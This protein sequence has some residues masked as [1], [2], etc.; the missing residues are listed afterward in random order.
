MSTSR[1]RDVRVNIVSTDDSRGFK[2]A[3]A[4]AKV[5]ERELNKLE[6]QQRRHVQMH[7]Q[8]SREMAAAEAQKA[9]A[10]VEANRRQ[11]DAMQTSGRVLLGVTAAIAVGMGIAAKAAWDWESSWAGVTKTVDGSPE[12]MAALERELRALA[13]TLPATH[14]EIAGVAE[15]AGQLGVRRQDIAG[16]TRT[17]IDLG[18]TTNLSADEAST[19]LAQ[20][21]NIMGLTAAKSSQLGSALVAL[22]NDGASTERDIMG[23]GLRI[24]GAGRTVGLTAPQVLA[25][26]SALSSLGIEAEAGGTAISRVMLQ[27]DSDIA[28]G[29][30]TVREYA[31]V[32]GMSADDFARKWRT[33]PA[34]ALDAFIKGLGRMQSAGQNTTKTLADLGL[35]EVRVSDTLRRA[36]L[37]GDLLTESLRTGSE[38]FDENL[39]LVEE[40][41]KR[42]ATTESRLQMARNSMNDAAIDIGG[43]LLPALAG[44]ADGAAS[45]AAGFG[46]LSPEVQGAVTGL[47]LAVAGVTGLVGTA[48]VAIPKLAEL[49]DLVTDLRGGSS[50][51]GR[52]L[53]GAASVLT[54]PWGLAIAGATV[55]VG[56]WLKLQGDARRA[57]DTL[58]ASL[59]Q[60]TGAMTTNTRATVFKQLQDEGRDFIEMAR[61]LKVDM[62]DLVDAALDPTS[63]A[64]SRLQGEADKVT[65]A[66]L[67]ETEA[68]GGQSDAAYEL[69]SQQQEWTALL[70]RLGVQQDRTA[71]AQQNWA[72]Q[73]EAGAVVADGA[74][75][76]TDGLTGALGEGE[77]AAKDAADAL[78]ALSKALDDLNGPA[79]DAR[80]AEIRFQE[81]IEGVSSAIADNGTALDLNT[82]QGRANNRALDSLAEAGARRAQALLE[83]TGSEEQFRASLAQ[84]R[85]ALYEAALQFG[86]SEEA[87]W[88]YVDQ[89]LKVPPAVETNIS[90]NTGPA[91]RALD[92]LIYRYNTGRHI[93]LQVYTKGNL[94]PYVQGYDGGGWTGPGAKYQIA[95]VV[96]A[97][98]HVIRQESRRSIE[99]AA[100]GYLD[101]LNRQGAAALQTLGDVA[102]RVGGVYVN[103]PSG[104]AAAPSASG[105]PTGP[106]V[107]VHVGQINTRDSATAVARAIEQGQRDALAMYGLTG[108]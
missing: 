23:M 58:T 106:Q 17:M 45:L 67:R 81:A 46:A 100:P 49:G 25:L 12:Q 96:H 8:A 31:R 9:A 20:F 69:A 48:A 5:L 22:G 28:S 101:A 82:E 37:A 56:Y 77:V 84:S 53:S 39:A 38:A 104:P 74:A 65:Q 6:Q 43:N 62:G 4:S 61:R 75:E 83:Q 33:S 26:A 87:A 73:V 64:M 55:A 44:A 10:I 93:E 85:Q 29:K 50:L 54:G 99:Q 66:L 94:T 95:G 1:S 98:E 70:E 21:S 102:S 60:Q 79:L 7:M 14:D 90:A 36:S 16:F 72:D 68:T 35:S 92:S 32:A 107:T 105:S 89:V 42:Y 47:G 3:E 59:D 76:S 24:A 103:G 97:D 41:N 91:E 40:A 2:S 13:R 19:S 88:A 11:A 15:A 57:V 51:L 63:A 71:Q 52:S 34:E 86:L 108:G 78:D 30:D 80:E 27:I 18:E